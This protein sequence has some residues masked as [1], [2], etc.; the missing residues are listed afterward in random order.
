MTLTE[1]AYQLL[2]PHLP[3]IEAFPIWQ[4]HKPSHAAALLPFLEEDKVPNYELNETEFQAYLRRQPIST[5]LSEPYVRV[6]RLGFPIGWLYK[7]RP[8]L[9]KPY[10]TL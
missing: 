1:A 10:L 7:G 8:S 6:L 9:P 3:K 5:G 4:Y 2:P